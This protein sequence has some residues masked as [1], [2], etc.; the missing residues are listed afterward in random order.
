M[1]KDQYLRLLLGAMTVALVSGTLGA[2]AYF[3]RP[4]PP[5]G[6]AILGAPQ[7]VLF[8]LDDCGWC[9]SFRRRAGREFQTT[10]MSNKAGLR[11]MSI[12]DGP[13][14]KRYKLHAFK[15]VPMLILFDA[16]GREMERTLT[17]PK[18]G[19]EVEAMVRRNLK[20]MPKA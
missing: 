20:R 12:E 4:E 16:Y 15:Q 18:D 17:E 7:L 2:L 13:P 5:V 9:Q 14:P 1:Q 3:S 11:Y 8:E 19:A 6:E 10:E